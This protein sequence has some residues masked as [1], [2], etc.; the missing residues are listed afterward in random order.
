[1]EEPEDQQELTPV[2][3]LMIALGGN[4]ALAEGCLMALRDHA[5]GL[6]RGNNQVHAIL[7]MPD[8]PEFRAVDAW[9]EDGS[10]M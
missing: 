6:E 8:G 10:L 5:C 7:F 4:L 2:G 9:E 3:V 1:M